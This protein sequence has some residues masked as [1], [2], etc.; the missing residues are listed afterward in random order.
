MMSQ[1]RD[2]EIRVSDARRKR[3]LARGGANDYADAATFAA[4]EQILRRVTEERTR[5]GLLLADL[6]DEEEWH[7]EPAVRLSS[8]RRLLGPVIL[9][10]KRTLLLPLTRWLYE[11]TA[12]NFR[13]Q[14]RVNRLLFACIEELAIENTRLRHLVAR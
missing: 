10:C 12:V 11:Y 8:H 6:L 9:F 4:V 2:L 13:R 7:L 5:S 14:E 3:L 1:Q